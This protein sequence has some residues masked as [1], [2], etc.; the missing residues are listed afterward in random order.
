MSNPGNPQQKQDTPKT[1]NPRPEKPTQ[2][3][4]KTNPAVQAPRGPPPEKEVA[5]GQ[6]VRKG[7]V[8]RAPDGG[9]HLL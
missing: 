8:G 1:Q 2:I 3:P 5:A 6:P 9:Q 4:Q 7:D